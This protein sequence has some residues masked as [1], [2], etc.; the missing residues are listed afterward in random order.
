[1]VL[2]LLIDPEHLLRVPVLRAADKTLL[3]RGRA[4]ALGHNQ[5]FPQSPRPQ[6]LAHALGSGVRP[7]HTGEYYLGF[8]AGEHSS[9]AGRVTEPVFVPVDPEYRHRRLLADPLGEAKGV[10]V[11]HDV[12]DDQDSRATKL[13]QMVGQIIRHVVNPIRKIATTEDFQEHGVGVPM[14]KLRLAREPSCVIRL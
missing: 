10:A 5:V 11:Q 7:H 1:M 2:D 6:Q 14:Q 12:A 4:P 3:P 9:Y 8:Q 13:V